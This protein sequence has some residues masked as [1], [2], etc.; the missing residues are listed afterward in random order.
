M[1]KNSYRFETLS[2]HAGLQADP[3]TGARAL[4]IYLSNAYQFK[5]TDNA[6]GLFGLKEE[7][8]IYT[9]IHNPTVTAFEERMAALEKGVGALALSSGMAAITTAILNLAGSGDEIIASTALYG[10]TY[11]L[12]AVTLPRYGIKTKFI[13]VNNTEE[14]EAAINENTKAVFAESIGNPSLV[15]LDT[16]KV[17]NVAHKH[18]LPLIVDNTFPTPYLHRPI[19][20]GA[21]IVVHSATKWIGGNGTNLGGVLVDGGTFDWN[22][23]KF[24]GFIEPDESYNG[25]VY[26]KDLG[27]LAFVMKARVQLLRDMGQAIS[28]FNA[29]QLALGLET[30]TV[31]MKEHVANTR[32]MVRFLENHPL[33]TWIR[34]PEHEEH[35]DRTLAEKYMPNGAGSV[36]VFGIKGGRDAGAACINSVQLWSHLANV[37]DAKSLIIHPASTTHQ[38]LSDEDLQKSGASEDLI[39]LSVGI[40]HIDDLIADLDQALQ[41]AAKTTNK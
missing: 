33:V 24:P 21:D 1:T 25:L 13:D 35:P 19:E 30:L 7:G 14:L 8:Y 5:D 6:A 39:R 16:E 3:A 38:Q 11:N 18:G 40:E 22:S 41:E 29:F 12:F 23:D 37:G 36:I 27:P 2:V 28:P 26:A 4:P 32:K 20:H 17:S 34:Y 15:I 9:R 10:G 31:R